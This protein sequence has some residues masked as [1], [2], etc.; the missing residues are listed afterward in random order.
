MR[1]SMG[2]STISKSFLNW[3]L[4][5][6]GRKK[7]KFDIISPL[8]SP[9]DNYISTN[10]TEALNWWS[11]KE[12]IKNKVFRV[13]FIGSFSKA[14]DFDTIFEAALDISKEKLNCE[15]ILC[16]D[17][18][19]AEYLKIKSKDFTNIK[20]I[21]WIDREKII[22]LTKISSAFIAPYKNNPDFVK[23]IP[24]K[25][26]DAFKFGLPLISPLKGEVRNLIKNYKVGVSYSDKKSL[27]ILL[28]KLISSRIICKSY[29]NNSIKLYKSKFEFN[30]VYNQLIINLENLKN[31]K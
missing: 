20:I 13:I 26:I 28:K 11:Q 12:V 1:Q 19:F 9:I 30:N 7:T 5:F 14:F 4:K 23:S 21:D 17:G 25:V 24:N 10:E 15:F 27:L 16:G 29:S 6:S 8:T 2:I 31:S 3:S 22:A 18:E